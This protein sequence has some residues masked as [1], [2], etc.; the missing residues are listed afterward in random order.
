MQKP[1]SF[2]SL[3]NALRSFENYWFQIVELPVAKG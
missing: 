3:V 2:E 1:G